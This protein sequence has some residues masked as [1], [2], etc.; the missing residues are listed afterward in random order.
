MRKEKIHGAL[1][2]ASL[3][4]VF[5]V[6]GSIESGSLGLF[7]GLILSLLAVASFGVN[8]FLGGLMYDGST[9]AHR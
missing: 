5:A 7:P 3:I 2:L 6:I 8:A 9:E 4:A 1:T